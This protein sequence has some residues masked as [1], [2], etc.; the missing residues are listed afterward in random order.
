M[1]RSSTVW[2]DRRER[3]RWRTDIEGSHTRPEVI[4]CLTRQEVTDPRWRTDIEGSHTHAEVIYCLT[5]QE[6]R[7]HAEEQ[8]SRGH[9]HVQRSSTVWPDR[10]RDP[11]W[12]TTSRGHTHVQRSSTVVT[13]AEEI[14]AHARIK[15][16][17]KPQSLSIKSLL[18]YCFW[19]QL[20]YKIQF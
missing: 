14:S 8:T 4:Y 13:L 3:S 17:N 10:R 15:D 18:K 11:C 12:R 6:E 2:P 5:R 1:Q 7:I 9:T 19:K 16:L 20:T